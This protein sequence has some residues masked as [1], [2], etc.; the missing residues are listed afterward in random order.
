MTDEAIICLFKLV[1]YSLFNIKSVICT[2]EIL[3]L[4]WISLQ[5]KSVW[6]SRNIFSPLILP[7]TLQHLLSLLSSQLFFLSFFL[8]F[9]FLSFF[10]YLITIR[11]TDFWF[12]FWI[13]LIGVSHVCTIITWLYYLSMIKRWTKIK[14]KYTKNGEVKAI[15]R[16]NSFLPTSSSSCSSSSEHAE[17]THSFDSFAPSVPI[18]HNIC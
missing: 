5:V 7:V 17:S 6:L 8:S 9:F 11:T 3:F 12:C 16:K 14:F 15:L 13:L 18:G 10:D 4:S 1:N 2:P